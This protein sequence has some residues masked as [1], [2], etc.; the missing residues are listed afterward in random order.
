MATTIGLVLKAAVTTKR[1]T[2]KAI[3]LL[4][5][6]D[7]FKPEHA[8]I[9]NSFAMAIWSKRDLSEKQMTTARMFLGGYVSALMEIAG[10]KAN[11][12]ENGA[13]VAFG[14]TQ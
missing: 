10:E 5:E 4:A 11:E 13:G 7:A 8:E 12:K 14:G 3:T 1:G 2:E 6:R 9:L